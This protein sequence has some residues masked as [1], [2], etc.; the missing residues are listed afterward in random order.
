MDLAAG[1]PGTGWWG[2]DGGLA[3]ERLAP[4]RLARVESDA[5]DLAVEGRLQRVLAAGKD[6]VLDRLGGVA[7]AR[8]DLPVDGRLKGLRWLSRASVVMVLP[9]MAS[10]SSAAACW[11]F[12]L[13]KARSNATGSARASTSLHI[14]Q[15][16]G[17]PLVT[18]VLQ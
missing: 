13:C 9:S 15:P 11:R 8:R 14:G 12:Q 6:R 17:L 5:R 4:E 3:A 10:P 18:R 16:H 7:T 2:Q 1:C